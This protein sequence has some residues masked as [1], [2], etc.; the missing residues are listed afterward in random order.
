MKMLN[1]LK[2]IM[3]NKEMVSI[4]GDEGD[5]DYYFTGYIQAVNDSGLLLSKQNVSGYNNGFVFFTDIIY[6][7]TDTV[8]TKRHE[9]LF[10][11]RNIKP[12]SFII[13][14]EKD[15]LEEV[16]KICR[17]KELCCNILKKETDESD[18]IGFISEIYD[19]YIIV[20]CIN[21]Y[22]EYYGKS[23][24]EKS[25]IFRIFIDG[26]FE[27]TCQLLYNDKYKSHN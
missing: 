27:R 22:G 2:K 11:L 15:L 8:D 25:H 18:E 24:I 20:K 17:E 7:E 6:F 10:Q 23:Y 26:E 14:S 21:K 12:D 13:N 1:E 3:T 4:C 9:R 19:E 16:L 5:Y